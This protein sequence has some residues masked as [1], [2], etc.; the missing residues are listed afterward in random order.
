M[1]IVVTG[2]RGQVALSLRE[3]GAAHGVDVVLVGRPAL[4]FGNPATIGPALRAARPDLVVNAAAFTAVDLAEAEEATAMRVNA[5]SAGEVAAEAARLGAPIIH[6]STDY[7]F[8]GRLDRPYREDDSVA[9]TG[10]YGRSKLA[11]E[12]A[13]ATATDNHIILRT[14]WIYSP[15]GKN[16]VRTML[17]LGHTRRAVRVVADQIGNPSYALDIADGILAVAHS[18]ARAR[19]DASLRGVFHLAGRGAASWSDLAEATFQAAA[20]LGGARLGVERIGSAD[21]PTSAR[22]PAN[23]QLDC[24]KLY[25]RY[26][27]ALPDWRQ[28]L[29]L[30]VARLVETDARG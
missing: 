29:K 24:G 23:S 11:G 27:I 26:G 17:A 21:Y 13:V 8:D 10:A 3:R 4:D 16:F 22:R 20:A 6:L 15:F 1:R 9:P 7:V 19:N 28:S 25:R 14:A 2:A 5:D 30:C 12:I 18:L